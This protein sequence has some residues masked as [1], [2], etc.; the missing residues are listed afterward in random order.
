[1]RGRGVI[2]PDWILFLLGLG[3]GIGLTAIAACIAMN[4]KENNKK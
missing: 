3:V 1:M 4:I 2:M